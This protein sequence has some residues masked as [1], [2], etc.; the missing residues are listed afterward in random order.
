MNFRS[1]SIS[2]KIWLS[3]SILILGYFLSMMYI[4]SFGRET[5]HRLSRVSKSVFPASRESQ[6]ALNAFKQQVK[7][8]KDAV[9][10]G[11]AQLLEKARET[12]ETVTASLA[13]IQGLSGL[14]D[15]INGRLRRIIADVESFSREAGAEYKTMSTGGNPDMTKIQ[16]LAEQNKALTAELDDLTRTFAENLKTEL[17]SVSNDTRQQSNYNLIAFFVILITSIVIIWLIISRSI[18]RP[19]KSTVK[20]LRDIR[21]GDLSQQLDTGNDEIG[22]MRGELN[23]VV[24]SLSEK[25]ATASEIANGNLNVTVTI[26]SEDDALGKAL[27]AMVDSLNEIV[28]GLL[29]AAAQV[30]SSSRHVADSSQSLSQGA[31]EQATS[32]EETTASM[33]QIGSQSKTNAENATQANQLAGTANEAATTG[34]SRMEEMV[35]AMERISGASNE[36][37]KIIKTIDDIAF[38]TNLL[39]LNAAV[40]AARAG[41]HGKGFAVVA[42]RK[43]VV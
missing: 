17:T 34:S 43:S 30:D 1:L 2:N 41:K 20:A 4:Y 6:A 27:E 33:T 12:S 11:D 18:I 29:D 23:A 40:E 26:N 9:M 16:E 32:V 15:E 21:R 14:S 13:Y 36:I 25:A 3:L 31:N 7:L 35:D 8:Y 22:V 39:A 5:E 42:D 10:M 24:E 19:L 38:Q 37:S 28:A